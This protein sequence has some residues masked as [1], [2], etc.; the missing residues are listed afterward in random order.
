MAE[1][2]V[3]AGLLRWLMWAFLATYQQWNVS[4]AKNTKR[5]GTGGG[6]GGGEGGGDFVHD[7]GRVTH[8]IT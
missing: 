3:Y 2:C 7:C 5:K 8:R 1:E 4:E 6:D